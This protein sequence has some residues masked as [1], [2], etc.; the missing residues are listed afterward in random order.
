LSEWIKIEM[1]KIIIVNV[2]LTGVKVVLPPFEKEE[3]ET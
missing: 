3:D 2:D 1:C